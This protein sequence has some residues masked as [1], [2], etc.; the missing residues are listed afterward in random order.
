[1]TDSAKEKQPTPFMTLLRNIVMFLGGLAA[2]ATLIVAWI[3]LTPANPEL[4]LTIT[5]V[6]S[7]TELPEVSGLTGTFMFN[8]EP[9]S[10]L[11]SI[12]VR[13]RN[14]GK[15][16][17]IGVGPRA[18]IL[19]DRLTLAA[20]DAIRILDVRVIRRDFDG[21]VYPLGDSAV[22]LSF[23]QWKVGE[24]VEFAV[25]ADGSIPADTSTVIA[26]TRREL[27]GGEILVSHARVSAEEAE[28]I[29]RSNAI[30]RLGPVTAG[31]IKAVAYIT[32]AS[33]TLMLVFVNIVLLYNGGRARHWYRKHG[34]NFSQFLTGLQDEAR[35][36]FFTLQSVAV[37]YTDPRELPEE[38]W[39][40]FEGPRY[41]STTDQFTGRQLIG[42]TFFT[43]FLLFG[44][45]AMYHGLRLL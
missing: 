3:Q 4:E 38:Y 17:I 37:I 34:P 27:V 2:V 31:L 6:E 40:Q 7:L 16:T 33:G 1:M 45:W 39:K 21:A 23:G 14:S 10:N 15:T 44:C 30:R 41:P 25:Y 12:R 43:L 11:L 42:Y 18:N 36:P 22:A 9:V 20:S 8:L 19:S 28:T 35:Q 24:V 32:L 5:D 13:I 26:P 29:R